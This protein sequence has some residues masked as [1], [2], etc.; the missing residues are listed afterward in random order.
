MRAARSCLP[1][2][3]CRRRAPDNPKLAWAYFRTWLSLVFCFSFGMF[4]RNCALVN[5]LP[6]SECHPKP[7]PSDLNFLPLYWPSWA[8]PAF[9]KSPTWSQFPIYDWISPLSARGLHKRSAD[10]SLPFPALWRPHRAVLACPP[11]TQIVIRLLLVSWCCWRAARRGIG[12]SA[13]HRL[14]FAVVPTLCLYGAWVG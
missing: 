8:Y 14:V 3:D 13:D 5:Y 1:V 2:S 6:G 11:P 10:L 4:N 12:A 7:A 9:K